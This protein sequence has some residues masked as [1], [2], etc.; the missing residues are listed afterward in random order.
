MN[1]LEYNFDCLDGHYRLAAEW[2]ETLNYEIESDIPE[3]ENR[4]GELSKEETSAFLAVLKKAQI[5]KW[6]REYLSCCEAIEDGI[7]WKVRLCED[8]REYVS[9]GE[10][11]FEPYDYEIFMDALRILEKKADFFLAKAE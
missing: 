1:R 11:S 5:E 3:F 10:E 6:D 9:K 7:R 4:S 8:G 2:D